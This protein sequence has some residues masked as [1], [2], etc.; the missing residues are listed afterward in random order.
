M[1]YLS[2]PFEHDVF[3]SYAHGRAE[4]PGIKGLKHWSERLRDELEAGIVE[5][6]REFE[7]LDIFID[8]QLD[9]TQPLSDLV[10]CHV[11]GS[12]LL[13][14]IMSERYLKSAWC[15]DERDWFET[16]VRRRRTSGGVVLVVRLQPTDPGA[17]PLCLKDE[18]GHVVLGFRFHPHPKRDEP[19]ELVQ[20]YGWPE[21][22]PQDRAYY[23]ELGKLASI[24][25]QRL[26]QLKQAQELDEKARRPRNQIRIEGEPS[27]YLQAPISTVAAW[28]E[29]KALLESAK[30]R[31]VPEAL[32]LVATD[33]A[34]IQA[35]HRERLKILKEMHALCLLRAPQANG[36][37]LEIDSIASDR[38]LLKTFDKDLPCVIINR[39][40]G[41]IPRARELGIETIKAPDDNWLVPLQA[42]L[43]R[44]L[45]R[46]G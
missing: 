15:Q 34:S 21:P 36:I 23:E 5:F 40:A 1:A 9:P 10:R 32:P 35:A 46:S 13:L 30:C 27:I 42:W 22:L 38:N 33:L 3:V 24:V 43:Q 26:R 16:E 11:I 31:V 41:D 12:G 45:D 28:A 25:T 6:V 4:R 19:D 7:P 44:A 8:R 18:R 17:W 2:K 37:D 29:A 20:P 39:G 14:V